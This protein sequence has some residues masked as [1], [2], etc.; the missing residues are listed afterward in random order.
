VV[1]QSKYGLIE[2][3]NSTT[4]RS[5]LDFLDCL[6]D[7]REIFSVCLPA[8]L[9]LNGTLVMQSHASPA[10]TVGVADGSAFVCDFA[11][12]DTLAQAST[13]EA[14]ELVGVALEEAVLLKVA[15]AVMLNAED[16]PGPYE[17]WGVQT[18]CGGPSGV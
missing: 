14:E 15:L 18:G 16:E 8:I 12:S 13:L 1:C 9:L 17:G 11:S 10:G 3:S 7:E 2:S 6:A 4:N 5:V